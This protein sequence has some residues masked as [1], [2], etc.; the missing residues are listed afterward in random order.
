M[1]EQSPE[2]SCTA[3]ASPATDLTDRLNNQVE[4][5]LG[6]AEEEGGGGSAE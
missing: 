2:S 3:S 1:S 5:G 4:E 6:E